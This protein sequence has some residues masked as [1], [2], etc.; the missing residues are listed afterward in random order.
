ML[1]TDPYVR[2]D[3][4]SPKRLTKEPVDFE[5]PAGTISVEVALFRS[6]FDTV[7]FWSRSIVRVLW[8]DPISRYV[9]NLGEND[10]LHLGFHSAFFAS[11]QRRGRLNRE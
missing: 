8:P 4:G 11:T 10:R 1:A 2:V 3:G 9:E 6:S 5:V 7:G